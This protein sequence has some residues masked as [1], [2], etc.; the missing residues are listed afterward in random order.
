MNFSM[1]W[2]DRLLEVV[3]TC[4]WLLVMSGTAPMGIRV[5]EY[6][7]T[8]T[9]KRVN[10]RTMNLLR[11]LKLMSFEN[12]I[13]RG[14]DGVI[15]RIRHPRLFRS[16]PDCYELCLFR[17]LKVPVSPNGGVGDVVM[18]VSLGVQGE[19]FTQL[20]QGQGVRNESQHLVSL[21]LLLKGKLL[22]LLLFFLMGQIMGILL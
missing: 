18:E 21:V 4:T 22:V 10:S 8:N 11:T 1:S 5:R 3:I 9:I 15:L 16:R 2:V 19:F 7:P 17:G 14:I 12:M 6:S 20:G 13:H